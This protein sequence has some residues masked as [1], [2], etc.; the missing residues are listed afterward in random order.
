M[1]TYERRKEPY[2]LTTDRSRISLDAVES[3][4]R[5]SYWAP[6]RP[7]ERIARSLETSLCFIAIDERDARAVG[8][9]RVVTDYADFAWLC[10]VFVEPDFRGAGLGKWLIE[11][12]LEHPDLQDLRR[13]IL[14][15][16]SAHGLYA[17]YGFTP[18]AN[19]DLWMERY[20]DIGPKPR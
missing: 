17:R 4:L 9:S 5:R 16:S 20:T 11:C 12:V 10:D 6:Q 19:P 3:F 8:F 15:T 14:A 13:V 2:L 1:Q 18:L 7:R